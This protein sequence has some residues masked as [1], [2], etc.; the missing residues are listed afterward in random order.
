MK[1]VD[2]TKSVSGLNWKKSL[3]IA[4]QKYAP[5]AKAILKVITKR[6]VRFTELAQ[7]V[8]SEVKDFNGSIEWYSITVL[9]QLEKEGK[10]IRTK[11]TIVTYQKP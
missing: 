10:V 8:K 4:N 3:N 6:P 7:L 9:R 1:K 2:K 5:L 11:G